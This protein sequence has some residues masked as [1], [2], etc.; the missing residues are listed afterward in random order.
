MIE[1]VRLSAATPLGAAGADEQKDK[2]KKESLTRM[3]RQ[4]SEP[5][6]LPSIEWWPHAR[7]TFR[8]IALTFSMQLRSYADA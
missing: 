5:K 8:R 6:Q 2:G 3:S 4:R 1:E 7:T